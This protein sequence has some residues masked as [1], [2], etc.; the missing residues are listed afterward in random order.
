VDQFKEL[1]L[2]FSTENHNTSEDIK[3]DDNNKGKF[4]I[5]S[6]GNLP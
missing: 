6:T 4:I 3:Y 5:L 2:T 1:H